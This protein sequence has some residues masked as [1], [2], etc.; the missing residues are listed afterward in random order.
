MSIRE[1]LT[2]R[3]WIPAAI[4]GTLA[5]GVVAGSI[6]Y[7]VIAG[8]SDRQTLCEEL[9]KFK[10][11]FHAQTH[12]QLKVLTALDAGK[13]LPKVANPPPIIYFKEHPDELR[14]A[15]PAIRASEK[16]LRQIDCSKL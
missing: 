3:W 12:D 10:A 6:G 2:H 14:K 8:K 5:L 15:L 11:P 16:N 13:P 1:V 9:N 4:V 7:A